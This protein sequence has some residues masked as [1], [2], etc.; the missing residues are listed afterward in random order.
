M[1]VAFVEFIY[2]K[3]NSMIEI[4]IPP[5][6]YIMWLKLVKQLARH[7]FALLWAHRFIEPLVDVPVRY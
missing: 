6:S 5:T 4:Y 2:D 1:K 3:P 7:T